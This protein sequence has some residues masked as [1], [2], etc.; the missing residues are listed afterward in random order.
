MSNLETGMTIIV[1]MAAV[2]A[3]IF[4][5]LIALAAFIVDCCK[6]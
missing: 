3:V 1:I 4:T 6:P 5:I 2:I